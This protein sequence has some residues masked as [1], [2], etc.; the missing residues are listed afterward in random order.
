M[1]W[2]YFRFIMIYCTAMNVVSSTAGSEKK[3]QLSI[4]IEV[5]P[6]KSFG[7]SGD[8]GIVSEETSLKEE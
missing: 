8:L 4:D 1:S 3:K 2:N 5:R 7:K 6:V